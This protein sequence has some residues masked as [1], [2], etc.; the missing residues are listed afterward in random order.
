MT[1][2]V[3]SLGSPSPA[4]LT[5]IMRNWNSLNVGRF[6]TVYEVPVTGV[7]LALINQTKA[8]FISVSFSLDEY[9]K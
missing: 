4:K 2:S 9:V 8:S 1:V 6:F 7:V 5:G 3:V